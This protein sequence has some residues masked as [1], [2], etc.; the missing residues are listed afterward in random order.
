MNI[1]ADPVNEAL[2]H[3]RRTIAAEGFIFVPGMALRP[4]IEAGGALEDWP[5]FTSSWDALDLDTYMA[6]GGR[7]RR[8]RYAVYEAADGQVERA[9]HAP[10]LQSRE[11]NRLH[12]DVERWFTP[13]AAEIGSGASVR[14]I[15]RFCLE[16]FAP[17][18]PQ[19]RHWHLEV[20][21]FRIEASPGGEG[22]PTP[23]G[24][25]R[26]GVDFVLAMLIRRHNIRSGTT[27]ISRPDGT[28][29]GSFT[30][31][32]AFD[33]ALIDD[34]RVYHGVTPVSPQDDTQPCYRDVIVVTLR[35]AA[36]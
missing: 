19:T 10:H 1:P 14:G 5:A 15:L 26:D 22:L 2:Q 29:L 7:Y 33:A 32:Q 35:A 20:H 18:R 25:H 24:M 23:E 28:P 34:A 16:L 30:L 6:D 11:Y 21:Q 8:R 31:A 3:L 9:P 17:L 12:G 4:L 36:A 13:I 27:A